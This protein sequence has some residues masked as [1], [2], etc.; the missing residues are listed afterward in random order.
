M[1][2]RAGLFWLFSK[3]N[4]DKWLLFRVY[5]ILLKTKRFG[6]VAQETRLPYLSLYTRMHESMQTHKTKQLGFKEHTVSFQITNGGNV[7][8]GIGIHKGL[9]SKTDLLPLTTVPQTGMNETTSLRRSAP[10]ILPIPSF[11]VG[12]WEKEA[13]GIPSWR[14]QSVDLPSFFSACWPQVG[15]PRHLPTQRPP[16]TPL[17][18]SKASFPLDAG[19]LRWTIFPLEMIVLIFAEINIHMAKNKNKIANQMVFNKN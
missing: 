6:L 12:H 9:T 10:T 19:K 16:T 4:V 1:P 2:V 17:T 15:Q 14:R 13:E 7:K 5:V 11:P 18:K 8:N 3:K